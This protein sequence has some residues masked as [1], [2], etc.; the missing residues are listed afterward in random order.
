M[1]T[2]FWFFVAGFLN[3]ILV[4]MREHILEETTTHAHQS[5]PGPTGGPS[6]DA[7]T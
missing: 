1:K 5:V 2:F 7:P 6:G 4:W 3:G